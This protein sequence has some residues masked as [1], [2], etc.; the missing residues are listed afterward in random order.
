MTHIVRN[1]RVYSIFNL[2]LF[3][4]LFKGLRFSRPVGKRVSFEAQTFIASPRHTPL[5][6]NRPGD[7]SASRNQH[8]DIKEE[9]ND[10]DAF[11]SVPLNLQLDQ[12]GSPSPEDDSMDV[13]SGIPASID[14]TQGVEKQQQPRS[15]D[16]PLRVQKGGEDEL[17]D[18]GGD[19][20]AL[21]CLVRKEML[22]PVPAGVFP[23]PLSTYCL[24]CI[25]DD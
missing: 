1:K 17:E 7:H 16:S 14:P 22:E 8:E 18:N 15:S 19:A 25:Q 3:F 10:E 23:Y 11:I 5:H 6:L 20:S 24:R 9:L 21:N 4:P 12:P 2:L 13:D